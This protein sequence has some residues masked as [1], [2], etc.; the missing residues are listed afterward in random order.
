MLL[1]AF[2]PPFQS[3]LFLKSNPHKP[4]RALNPLFVCKRERNIHLPHDQGGI[5]APPTARY[6]S[7]IT[8]VEGAQLMG[9]VAGFSGRTIKFAL[10]AMVVLGPGAA[11][12]KSGHATESSFTTQGWD[13]RRAG[14]TEFA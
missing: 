8:R 13:R 6:R 5:V 14:R 3:V 12:A 10:L 2:Q 1:R 4:H 7:T 11:F 9:D